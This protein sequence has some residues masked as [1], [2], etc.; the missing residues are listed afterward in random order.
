MIPVGANWS[1]RLA[2]H[3]VPTFIKSLLTLHYTRRMKSLPLWYIHFEVQHLPRFRN[4][5]ATVQLLSF[6]TVVAACV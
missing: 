5:T 6:S 1:E 4:N 2:K 3:T